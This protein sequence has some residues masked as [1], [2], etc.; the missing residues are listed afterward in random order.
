MDDP[1]GT[2]RVPVDGFWASQHCGTAVTA[3]LA[4]VLGCPNQTETVRS[5]DIKE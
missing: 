1:Q 3:C 4:F 2:G 5:L